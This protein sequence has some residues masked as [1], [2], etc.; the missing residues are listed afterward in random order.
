MCSFQQGIQNQR[1]FAVNRS[2]II[3]FLHEIGG[4]TLGV[5]SAGEEAKIASDSIE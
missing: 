4:R 3:T 5:S 1:P 2:V